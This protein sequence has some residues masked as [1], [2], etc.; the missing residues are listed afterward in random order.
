MI[1]QTCCFAGHRPEKLP[2]GT[3]ETSLD[4]VKLKKL[5]YGQ[6]EQLVTQFGVTHF[7]SGMAR[8][9]D[10][11]GAETVLQLKKTYPVTLECVISFEGQAASWPEDDR[12][13]YFEIIA[14]ADKET[15]FQQHFTPDCYH[16]RSQHMVNHSQF[17]IAVWDGSSSG[18]SGT[19]HYAYGKGCRVLLIH[20]AR[21][22]MPP[23]PAG[24]MEGHGF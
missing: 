9:I 13:R 19:V 23:N 6:A 2:W 21:L 22:L 5:L 12:K 10:T 15:M 24:E 4:C 17:M 14:Q 3:D 7:I 20:P 18:T 1:I 16:N 11:Y 8:G